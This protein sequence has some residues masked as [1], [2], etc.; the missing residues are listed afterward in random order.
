VAVLVW[1]TYKTVRRLVELAE[2]ARRERWTPYLVVSIQCSI[3]NPGDAHI[4]VSNLGSGPAL[5]VEIQWKGVPRAS[6]PT[7]ARLPVTIGAMGLNDSRLVPFLTHPERE[8]YIEPEDD[9]RSRLS[10][11]LLGDLIVSYGDILGNK[12]S[13]VASVRAP[14]IDDLESYCENL[15]LSVRKQPAIAS[16]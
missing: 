14:S 13:T 6:L 11:G 15:S 5:Q 12:Y 1:F 10:A 9:S 8:S 2:Q 3:G 4:L 7:L 16:S